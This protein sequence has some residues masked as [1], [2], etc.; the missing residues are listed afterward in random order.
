MVSVCT[1][2][3]TKTTLF[4]R[5]MELIPH[6]WREL[7]DQTHAQEIVLLQAVLQSRPA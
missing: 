1:D 4:A 5:Y 3:S 2:P 7:Q 6:S